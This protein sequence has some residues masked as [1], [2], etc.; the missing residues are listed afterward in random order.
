MKK[1]AFEPKNPLKSSFG[2]QK[3]L[4]SPVFFS[5]PVRPSVSLSLTHSL[6]L[7]LSL[8]Q[9]LYIRNLYIRNLYI[10]N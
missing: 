4:Y 1:R 9:N 10:R 8:F 5:F 3:P 2:G 7:F 6:S